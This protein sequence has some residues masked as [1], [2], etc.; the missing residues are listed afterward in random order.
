MTPTQVTLTVTSAVSL[1][2][3]AP[4][5]L[6]AATYL[7]LAAGLTWPVARAPRLVVFGD[8]GDTRGWI[9]WMWAKSEGLLEGSVHPL[10]AAP[11][12]GDNA[13][14]LAQ[15]ITEWLALQLTRA[16]DEVAAANL[17]VIIALTLTAFSTYVVVERLVSSRTAAFLAGVAF[18]F[19]PAAVMQAFGGHAAYAFN[20]FVPLFVLAL[21]HN[22]GRRTWASAVS[23]GGSFAGIMFSAAYF[24]YFA[25]YVWIYFFAFECYRERWRGLGAIVASH[26]RAALTALLLVLP[27]AWPAIVSQLSAPPAALAASGRARGLDQLF[28]FSSR[29]WDFF[30]PSIDHPVLGAWVEDFV[31]LHLH[32]SNVFEQTLYLGFVPLLLVAVGIVL[33]FRGR[34]S[35]PHANCFAFL[36]FGAAWMWLVSLPPQ[37]GD[38]PTPSYFGHMVAPMFRVYARAGI[39]VSF[40]VAAAAAV[41]LAHLATRLPKAVFRA[42][43]G[44]ALSILVFEFWS[45]PPGAARALATPKV[46]EWLAVQ[47]V[48]VVAEYPMVDHAEATF[49][50]YLFWQRVHRKKLVNGATPENPAAWAFWHQVRDLSH[51]ETP[52]RLKAAGVEYVIVHRDMYREGPIPWALKRYYEPKRA[53]ATLEGGVAPEPPH[54]L[55]PVRAFGGDVVYKFRP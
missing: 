29:P 36:C 22:L 43:A 13:P 42:V 1:A 38:L 27:V 17:F 49:Y 33:A 18:G 50:S 14:V 16:V 40:F 31:R 3:R 54:A 52:A 15:P 8:Y 35:P 37:V 21:F 45:L 44:G 39:F 11:Y 25:I 28:T 48:K 9:A 12:G 32:G 34:F 30:L 53:A 41:V 7:L 6:V 2:A 5:A 20:V 26:A 51:P 23:V 46:Y 4:S 47:P 55:E 19:C 10:V 24:A